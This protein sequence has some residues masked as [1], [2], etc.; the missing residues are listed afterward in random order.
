MSLPSPSSH[1]KP[2]PTHQ[3]PLYDWDNHTVIL[4]ITLLGTLVLFC[5]VYIVFLF[6]SRTEVRLARKFIFLNIGISSILIFSY[7][8]LMYYD[9]REAL[10]AVLL[11]YTTNFDI[12]LSS[13]S[14]SLLGSTPFTSS[15]GYGNKVTVN[16]LAGLSLV[17][18]E[19]RLVRP[20][21]GL[22]SS[23]LSLFINTH[24]IFRYSCMIIFGFLASLEILVSSI[25][26]V[27]LIC[28]EDTYCTIPNGYT[29]WDMYILLY[30]CYITISLLIFSILSIILLCGIIG[31]KTIRYP[32]ILFSL[33]KL[34][35][36]THKARGNVTEEE[37]QSGHEVVTASKHRRYRP[38]AG[39]NLR[40][41]VQA[42]VRVI[43][44]ATKEY[45]TKLLSGSM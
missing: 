31:Y 29:I 36:I 10:Q 18:P 33:Q 2:P 13:S 7:S 16:H 9:V 43:W 3:N 38:Q 4:G 37:E 21:I 34:S 44:G 30:R 42:G 17:F 28:I 32:I 11:S 27:Q 24:Y 20:L 39:G 6:Q 26:S 23:I 40:T 41:Q 19:L 25:Y 22:L 15:L 45:F 12:L 14:T 1:S 35:A 5:I 8:I